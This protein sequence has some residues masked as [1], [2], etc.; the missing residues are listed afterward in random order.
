MTVLREV[1]DGAPVFLTKNGRGCYVVVDMRE[2]ERTRM[3]QRLFDDI[4]S[5]E[6]S[7]RQGGWLS[8]DEVKARMGLPRD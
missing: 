2:W 8:T 5:G 7:A 3:G 4:Q 6:A 1:D